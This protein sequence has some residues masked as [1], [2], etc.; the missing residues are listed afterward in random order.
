MGFVKINQWVK[1]VLKQLEY[2]FA[3]IKDALSFA[4]KDPKPD[5]DQTVKVYNEQG[6]LV[7]ANKNDLDTYA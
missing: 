7:E 1:G 4:L 3:T 2:E 5:P 6:E